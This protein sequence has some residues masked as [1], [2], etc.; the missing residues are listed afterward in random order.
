MPF[1]VKERNAGPVTILELGPRLTAEEGSELKYAVNELLAQGRSAILLDCVRLG[2]ID[3]QGIAAL[4]KTWVSA[5]RGSKLKLFSLT[6]HLKEVDLLP[7]YPLCSRTLS[8]QY[9]Q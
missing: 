2:F 1:I 4:V 3:S 6:P 7:I 5:G 8:R 9:C